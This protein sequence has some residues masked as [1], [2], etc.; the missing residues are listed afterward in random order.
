M[1]SKSDLKK[2]LARA[3]TDKTFRDQLISN[4]AA[5][6]SAMNVQLSPEQVAALKQRED[7]IQSN[8]Q[9]IDD[10]LALTIWL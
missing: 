8:G 1:A 6:A 10:I 9:M 7:E 2:L 5:A 3:I 4:P